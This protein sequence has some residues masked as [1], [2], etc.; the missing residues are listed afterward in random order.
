M[1]ILVSSLIELARCRLRRWTHYDL[2]GD[3][4]MHER[5]V[6]QDIREA[7]VESM[8]VEPEQSDRY[9]AVAYAEKVL[10]DPHC[11]TQ[12]VRELCESYLQVVEDRKHLLNVVAVLRDDIKELK[13]AA[14]PSDRAMA[15]ARLDEANWWYHKYAWPPEPG[16]RG[17]EVEAIDRIDELERAAAIERSQT[18]QSHEAVVDSPREA[19]TDGK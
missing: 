13:S 4:Q 10:A 7:M 6:Q 3:W 16:M 19:R 2:K 9:R 18:P 12:K 8:G 1:R 17:T 14:G 5:A 15:G 11:G